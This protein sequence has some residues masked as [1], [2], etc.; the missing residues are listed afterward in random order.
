[1]KSKEIKAEMDT[2]LFDAVQKGDL[3]LVKDLIGKGADV[4]LITPC[5]MTLLMTAAIKRHLDIITVR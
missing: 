2:A 4:N 1:M 5:G 3:R